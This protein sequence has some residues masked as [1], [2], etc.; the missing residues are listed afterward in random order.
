MNL[1]QKKNG[2]K[3]NLAGTDLFIYSDT[4]E[5]LQVL[6][7]SALFVWSLCDMVPVEDIAD[8]LKKI[9]PDAR[10]EELKRDT[11]ECI[12]QLIESGLLV[13]SS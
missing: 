4:G 10:I 5:E 9:Y 3:E 12:N 2:L 11:G 1:P 7:S 8:I 13:A 6:N